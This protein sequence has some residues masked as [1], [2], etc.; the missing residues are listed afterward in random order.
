MPII[1]ASGILHGLVGLVRVLAASSALSDEWVNSPMSWSPD[2]RW[3]T[4][5]VIPAPA[6]PG[7]AAGW[8]FDA[9]PGETPAAS[10]PRGATTDSERRDGRPSTYQIWASRSDGEASVRIEESR[11]PLSAPAWRPRGH[12]LAFSR[13]VP[14]PE[15][16]ADSAVSVRGQ[17]ELV[18][19]DGLDRKRTVARF[20]D[21]E[22]DEAARERFAHVAPAW[23]P[24]GQF[25]A[26]TTP[27]RAPAIRVVAVDSGKTV[28]TLDGAILPA[29]SVDGR[30][31][32]FLHEDDSHEYSIQVAERQGE[33]FATAREI[34]AVGH[35]PAPMCWSDDGRSIYA[36]IERPGLHAPD[37]DLT[38][39]D[40]ERSEA[41]RIFPIV[42]E[43]LR[44]GSAIRGLAIDFG[45]DGELCFFSVDMKGRD[46]DVAWTVPRDRLPYSRFV[47]LDQSLRVGGIAIAPDGHAVALRFGTPGGL[48]PPAICEPATERLT[49]IAADESARREWVELLVSTSRRLLATALPSAVSEG[50]V[51]ARPTLLPLPDELPTALGKRLAKLGRFGSEMLTA[52]QPGL[53]RPADAD[54]DAAEETRTAAEDRLFFAY[55]RGDYS[56]AETAL[57]ALE[58]RLANRAERLAGLSLRAQILWSRGELERARDVARYLVEAEGGPIQRIEE[59]PLGRSVSLET[60]TGRPWARYL[61]TRANQPPAPSQPAEP[62][63]GE[64]DDMLANPFAPPDLPQIPNQ[65]GGVVPFVPGLR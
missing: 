65:P 20:P 27:G 61:L 29:W 49:L 52:R 53:S 12:A 54:A 8:L 15:P 45:H 26:V 63:A 31:L 5:T 22:L 9:T 6:A 39:I 10:A 38:R 19:Q 3:L 58:P 23:S 16:V 33:A 64:R 11:W 50:E 37:L 2:G 28:R 44:R 4:Y 60:V 17:V 34:L 57:D 43:V 42:P 36:A 30:K 14:G 41:V 55:L 56:A 7:R 59:T 1:S 47:P 40:P 24:D 18:V 35:L 25:L 13:F 32:A 62:A 46:V 51:V 21:Y 48:S